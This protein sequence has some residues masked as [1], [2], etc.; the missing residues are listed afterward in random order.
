MES[1]STIV[2]H[3]VYT[4]E[5]HRAIIREAMELLRTAK[6]LFQTMSRRAF[7][8]SMDVEDD[9]DRRRI[10]VRASGPSDL[11]KLVEDLFS[12]V[13][14]TNTGKQA[15]KKDKSVKIL[16]S[17]AFRSVEIDPAVNGYKGTVTN[18]TG[19]AHPDRVDP[20]SGPPDYIGG[21]TVRATGKPSPT[22]AN[23][24]QVTPET[25][26]ALAKRRANTRPLQL[27]IQ[28]SLAPPGLET[29][30]ATFSSMIHGGTPPAE[31]MQAALREARVPGMDETML[32][33]RITLNFMKEEMKNLIYENNQKPFN[34]KISPEQLIGIG[35]SMYEKVTEGIPGSMT[36]QERRN[37]LFGIY[38]RWIEIHPKPGGFRKTKG[39]KTKRKNRRHQ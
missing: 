12:G 26:A 2:F 31:A 3:K 5:T 37:L 4:T 24:E 27:D 22:L 29:A 8:F 28:S 9:E 33:R 18:Y 15:W 11:A 39:R 23:V 7:G 20:N 19:L 32:A 14:N 21:L 30:V 34:Q 38:K 13:T 16:E 25:I 36:E 10:T 35:E 17:I 6:E 1:T